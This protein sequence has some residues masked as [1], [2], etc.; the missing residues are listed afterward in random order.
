MTQPTLQVYYARKLKRVTLQRLL[1][2]KIIHFPQD[3]TPRDLLVLVDN[4]VWLQEKAQK[5]PDFRDKFGVTLKVLAY[6][7]KEKLGSNFRQFTKTRITY[8]S[9]NF[10][11]NLGDFGLEKRNIPHQW[12]LLSGHFEVKS[13]KPLGT[14][15]SQLPP[16]QYIGVGYRDKG[17][18][19]NPAEDGSPS[20]QEVAMVPFG[21][22]YEKH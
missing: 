14:L 3:V 21:R 20:W 17:T 6:I 18:A 10:K 2:G 8:L 16:A 11:T 7:I 1:V 22:L 9:N 4:M 13:A 15:K 5:D 12:K 19:K